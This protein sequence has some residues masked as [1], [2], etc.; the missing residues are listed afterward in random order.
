MR[1]PR[2]FIVMNDDVPISISEQ[3]HQMT[4][5]SQNSYIPLVS[6]SRKTIERQIEVI[7]KIDRSL[8]GRNQSK[9]IVLSRNK[10][11]AFTLILISEYQPKIYWID[12]KWDFDKIKECSKNFDDY[13]QMS[14]YLRMAE[15]SYFSAFDRIKN[16]SSG[17]VF[18]DEYIERIFQLA[19]WNNKPNAESATRVWIKSQLKVGIVNRLDL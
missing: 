4:E 17:N 1:Y 13:D 11:D 16:F 19:C 9:V 8:E 18:R 12:S 2:C 10:I 15:D 7:R 6:K 3:L 14:Y 5:D